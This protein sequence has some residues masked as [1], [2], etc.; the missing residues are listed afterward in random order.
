VGPS[1]LPRGRAGRRGLL[2]SLA[3]VFLALL[4]VLPHERPS[5]IPL[6]ARS[7]SLNT[8]DPAQVGLGSL[9]YRG[10]LWLSSPDS[11][12]GGFSDL[13]VSRNGQRLLAI[14]DCGYQL[15]ANL[16]YGADGSLS[17]LGDAELN[18]LR[19]PADLTHDEGDAEGLAR[20]A[21]GSLVVGYERHHRLWRYPPGEPP[22]RGVAARL[23]EIPSFGHLEPNLGIEAMT[24]L[25]DGRLLAIGE[26][27]PH[28]PEEATAWVGW[29]HTWSMIPFP[30]F[31]DHAR[32]GAPLRP[33]GAALLPSGEVLVL[34][35][36]YP[37]LAGRIRLIE[38]AAL[39]AGQMDGR[40]IARLDEPFPLHNF[41][42]IDARGGAEGETWIYLL[43]DDN[44]CRTDPGPRRRSPERTLLLAFTLAAAG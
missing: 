18:L 33:T 15:A 22:L 43:S 4:A 39:E 1:P 17:D 31:Y 5:R 27:V 2:L 21:D 35:R 41:E 13:R 16:L 14:S 32:S 38:R 42:G 7:I 36:R 28:G 3:A 12:F 37:P 25:A 19:A 23:P 10:G 34:E 20:M 30:L 6:E 24:G 44:S 29:D 26:L 11:R 9:R 40:E 8:L